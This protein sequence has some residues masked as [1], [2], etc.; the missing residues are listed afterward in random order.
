M[1]HPNAVDSRGEA[2]F[3][4]I[5]VLT[6]LVIASFALVVLMRGLGTSQG[7][8]IYLESHLGARLLAR[9]ILEDER[10]DA[11]TK[12]GQRSGD[13]GQYHWSLEVES[14]ELAGTSKSNTGGQ[15]YKLTVEIG[16]APRGRLVLDTMKFGK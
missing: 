2:G 12:T 16:W 7:S 6:A 10:Q 5:E 1:S 13:S 9:S 11:E 4:L 8:A 14:T 3:S 15:L